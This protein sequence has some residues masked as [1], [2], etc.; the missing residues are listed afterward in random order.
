MASAQVGGVAARV[1]LLATSEGALPA[2]ND[3]ANHRA[4]GR[5]RALGRDLLAA[6]ELAGL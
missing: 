5:A 1:H 4:M 2:S 3:C 6:P